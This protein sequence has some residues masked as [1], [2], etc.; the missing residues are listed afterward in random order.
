MV[1]AGVAD[2]RVGR[3]STVDL[4]QLTRKV[5][6]VNRDTHAQFVFSRLLPSYLLF[7]VY[8]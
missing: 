1:L 3:T 2:G 7:L 8:H 5:E 6:F 4:K